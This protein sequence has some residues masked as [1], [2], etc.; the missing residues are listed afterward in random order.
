VYEWQLSR[1][2]RVNRANAANDRIPPDLRALRK[3]SELIA[4]REEICE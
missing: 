3:Q 4:G 2:R 1:E